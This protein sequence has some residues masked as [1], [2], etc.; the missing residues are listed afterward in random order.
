MINVEEKC[1]LLNMNVI[2]KLLWDMSIEKYWILCEI[3]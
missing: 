3:K 1:S 2:F